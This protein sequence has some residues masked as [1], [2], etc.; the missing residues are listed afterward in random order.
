MRVAGKYKAI[1]HHP[2]QAKANNP[3]AKPAREIHK[4]FHLSSFAS[5]ASKNNQ[6]IKI[7]KKTVYTS[8][9]ELSP[10]VLATKNEVTASKKAVKN[11]PTLFLV[12]F[13]PMKLTKNNVGEFFTAFLLAVTSF[14]V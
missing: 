8:V 10:V 3:V 1:D 4:N 2:L 6:V 9:S 11:P 5:K 14:F 12:S 13:L 7:G